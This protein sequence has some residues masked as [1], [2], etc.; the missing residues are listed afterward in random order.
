MNKG[1]PVFEQ[2]TYHEIVP[3][4]ATIGTVVTTITADDPDAESSQFGKLEY[5]LI[6]N[7]N[8]KFQIDK[9]LGHITVV[10]E[11]DAEETATHTII[12]HVSEQGGPNTA[13][14]SCIIT[15]EDENDNDPICTPNAFSISIPESTNATTDI[16]TLS[17]SDADITSRLQYTLLSGDPSLF[18]I[19]D[20]VLQLISEIDFDSVSSD[21]FSVLI[22]VSDEINTVQVS[23]I[24]TV[25]GVNEASPVFNQGLY[26]LRV[27]Q[28]LLLC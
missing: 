5:K 15:V 16:N 26:K 22:A 24:V 4:S 20:N 18:R 3:E 27:P 10:S 17:C 8:N 1:P 2:D 11:L 14:A 23:G 28:Q 13:T 12:V 25:T 6:S 19:N 9:N 21:V 7:P